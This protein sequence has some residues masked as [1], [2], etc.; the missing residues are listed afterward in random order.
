MSYVSGCAEPNVTLQTSGIA[1]NKLKQS[2]EISI[3]IPLLENLYCWDEWRTPKS[4]TAKNHSFPYC[5]AFTW[6]YRSAMHSDIFLYWHFFL[7]KRVWIKLYHHLPK[8]ATLV[9][10]IISWTPSFLDNNFL[11]CFYLSLLYHAYSRNYLTKWKTLYFCRQKYST[12]CPS[13]PESWG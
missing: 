6:Q 3:P 12:S 1:V 10:Y 11:K 7:K 5:I 4:R 9:E 8:I 2:Y 13:L